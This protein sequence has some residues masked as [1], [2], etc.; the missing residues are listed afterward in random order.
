LNDTIVE[1][2]VTWN[3]S[4][5]GNSWTSPGGD[6][7]APA[8]SSLVAQQTTELKTFVSTVDFV[9]AAQ[10]ALAAGEPL[11]LLVTAL[12]AEAWGIANA[13][14]L[15]MRF[16]SDD[17]TTGQRPTLNIRYTLAPTLGD[18]NQDELVNAADYIAWRKGVTAA[19][20]EGEYQVWRSKFGE[21]NSGDASSPAVP[22]PTTWTLFAT[23]VVMIYC[24]SL[25]FL[26]RR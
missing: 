4:A 10:Q 12:D 1:T 18:F 16:R 11:G 20:N 9:A 6:F 5:A 13:S 14:N 24:L 26:N 3:Q 8:L 19:P 15:N 7:T 25:S 22:E 21:S 17:A 2:Q 23:L